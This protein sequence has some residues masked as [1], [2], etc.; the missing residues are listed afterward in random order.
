MS[1]SQCREIPS[2]GQK[3]FYQKLLQPNHLHRTTAG[4]VPGTDKKENMMS[5]AYQCPSEDLDLHKLEQI[6][7][8]FVNIA[9]LWTS[10]VD[11]RAVC[12]PMTV[13]RF[14]RRPWPSRPDAR[15]GA[16]GHCFV[17]VTVTSAP[18]PQSS[19]S[20]SLNTNVMT[21]S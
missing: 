20:S 17:R 15:Y 11:T 10:Q 12:A 3:K 8:N 21:L 19:I 14:H 1:S 13:E 4:A 5:L 6:I 7:E 18:P 9:E 16:S 2:K